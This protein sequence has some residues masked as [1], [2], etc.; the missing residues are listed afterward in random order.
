MGVRAIVIV[1]VAVLL[2][3]LFLLVDAAEAAAAAAVPPAVALACMCASMSREKAG[4]VGFSSSLSF[5]RSRK[6]F[7]PEIVTRQRVSSKFMPWM[8]ASAAAA[9]RCST[10]AGSS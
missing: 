1:I 8:S 7:R 5:S 9:F 4:I 10:K 6:S 2:L 3:P